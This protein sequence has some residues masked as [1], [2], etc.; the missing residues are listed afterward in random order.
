METK[1]T[2]FLEATPNRNGRIQRDR[3]IAVCLARDNHGDN[4]LLVW[5]GAGSGGVSRVVIC[6]SSARASHAM[7]S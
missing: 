1:H 3:I 7:R 2:S 6:L 4:E 5:K